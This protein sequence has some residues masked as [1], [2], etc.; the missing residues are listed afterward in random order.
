MK[1]K[2][3]KDC[4]PCVET[5]R[6]EIFDRYSYRQMLLWQWLQSEMGR[7]KILGQVK[8][9]ANTVHFWRVNLYF[10]HEWSTE[11]VSQKAQKISQAENQQQLGKF[12]GNDDR[13]G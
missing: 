7:W 4:K 2:W 8:V 12:S 6:N 13:R 1:L 3:L 5:S 11:V 9:M 10:M